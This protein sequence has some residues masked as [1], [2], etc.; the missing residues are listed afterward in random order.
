MNNLQECINEYM[1]Y[2][3]T[4]NYAISKVCQDIIISRIYNSKYK[5]RITFKGGVVMFNMT[6]NLRRATIDIDMDFI[7]MS[8]AT[9]NI[10]KVFMDLE[11][12]KNVDSF[13]IKIDKNKIEELSQQDYHGKD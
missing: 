4:R 2:G 11:N 8:I 1:Q 10:I 3:Y 13:K 12:L 5:D 9:D 6:Q 7:N